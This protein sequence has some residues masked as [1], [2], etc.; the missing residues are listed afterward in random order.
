V[1]T[2]YMN[3]LAETNDMNNDASVVVTIEGN[4]VSPRNAVTINQQR[5]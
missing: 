1:R 2:D 5:C 4:S 3:R